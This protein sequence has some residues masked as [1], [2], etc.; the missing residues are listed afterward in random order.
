MNLKR[1]KD[2]PAD[3]P[4]NT[5]TLYKWHH[6]KRYPKMLVKFGGK[7]LIDLDEIEAVIK[8]GIAE[9]GGNDD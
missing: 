6:H 7:L 5:G 2:L 1:V 4:V 3:F 9:K 8:S